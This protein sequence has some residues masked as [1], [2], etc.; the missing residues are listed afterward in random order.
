MTTDTITTAD[1][2]MMQKSL[3]LAQLEG[4]RLRAVCLRWCG[5]SLDSTVA[6]RSSSRN[7]L[8]H[9]RLQLEHNSVC[10]V[11]PGNSFRQATSRCAR[12]NLF[13]QSFLATG[14]AGL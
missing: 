1:K 12:H 2:I 5:W 3:G 14:A 6:R 7:P 10:A 13:A 4:T 8:R 11:G 9:S